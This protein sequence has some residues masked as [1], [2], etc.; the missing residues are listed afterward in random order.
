[1]A[2]GDDP[3]HMEVRIQDLDW[4][5]VETSPINPCNVF[6][7]QAH[8]TGHVLNCGFA[9]PP[10]RPRGSLKARDVK[11]R[12]GA[13]VSLTRRDAKQLIAILQENLNTTPEK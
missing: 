9:D 11:V 12:L 4:S 10:I 2:N 8:E 6:I 13:R 1:M 7:A 3:K 5:E